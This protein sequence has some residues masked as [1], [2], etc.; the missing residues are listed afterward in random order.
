MRRPV[1]APTAPGQESVWDYPRPPRVE[2]VH[3][4]VTITLGG[5][6]ILSTD[7]VVR[8]LETSHPPVYYVPIA[9]F[10]PGALTPADGSSFCEFKGGARYFDVQ[11]GGEIREG[12]AW[13]YP[14][15][16][17]G[18]EQLVGRVAVYAQGMDACTVGDE[19]V[20][21]QP[22]RF[23]GGWVTSWVVGPFKGTPGSMGW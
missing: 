10:V 23:Y 15:P 11:G 7:D 13:T 5:V 22:G 8:V 14:T 6:K 2:K 1:P 9:D 19:T 21:P 16:T 18:F 12:A 3:D 17:R 4:R 20:E